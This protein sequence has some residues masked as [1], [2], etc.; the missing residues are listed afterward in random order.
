MITN[1]DLTIYNKYLNVDKKTEEYLATKITGVHWHN[2]LRSNVGNQGDKGLVSAEVYKIRIPADADMEGKEY[3]DP[4]EYRKLPADI[5]KKYWTVERGD[6]ILKGL[7]NKSY[8]KASE[9]RNRVKV[10][11]FSDNRRGLSPH[12][13]VGGA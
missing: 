4:E 8:G 12:F 3:I 11:S 7:S 5:V 6:L 13:R 10:I 9:A 1:A 2:D